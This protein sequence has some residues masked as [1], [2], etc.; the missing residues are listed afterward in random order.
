[1]SSLE[2]AMAI[3]LHTF[4]KYANSDGVK[5]TMSQSEV[6][7][8]IEK[9]LPGLVKAA[10]N[11]DQVEKFLKSLDSNGDNMVD[12]KEFM[13]LVGSLTCVAHNRFIK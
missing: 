1:M 9:E 13:V 2:S 12:F 7:T 6:K 4:D 10:K 5:E 3:L 8:L 11:P